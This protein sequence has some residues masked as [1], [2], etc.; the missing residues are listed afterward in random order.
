MVS[1][2]PMI[3]LIR[4]I[5]DKAPK[6]PDPGQRVL[7]FENDEWCV[8]YRAVSEPITAETGEVVILVA[9]EEE[10]RAAR[11]DGRFPVGRPW[12]VSRMTVPRSDERRARRRARR[13]ARR[14]TDRSPEE[15]RGSNREPRMARDRGAEKNRRAE[16]DRK[17]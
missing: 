9:K 16:R 15:S 11:W 8:G 7:L 1:F 13:K 4:S 14:Q 5:L 10:F 12:P 3:S 2:S 6:V 17:V